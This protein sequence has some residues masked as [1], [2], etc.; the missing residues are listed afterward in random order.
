MSMTDTKTFWEDYLN[1][2]RG[3]YE[4]R[5]QRYEAVGEVMEVEGPFRDGC[6]NRW[7]SLCDVGAGRCEFRRYMREQGWCGQYRAVDGSIDGTD[8]NAWEPRLRYDWFV[9]IEVLEHLDDP[10]TLMQKLVAKARKGVVITTPNAETVDVLDID[11][12]HVTPLYPHD[13][14]VLGWQHEIRSFFCKENDSI[15]AWRLK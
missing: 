13:F 15:L 1:A 2:R 12:T 9:A 8:L 14:K 10:Y 3:T 7:D 6:L 4:F 5:C 11:P